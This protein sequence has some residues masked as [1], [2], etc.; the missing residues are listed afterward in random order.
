MKYDKPFLTYDQQI[1]HLKTQYKLNILNNKFALEALSSVSYYD[2]ING[3]K[4][5]MMDNGVFK[6][7]VSIE[8]L[9]LFYL[10]DKNFQNVI[11][12]H[13]LFVENFFKTKLAYVLAEDFG[14]DIKDYLA[15]KNLNYSY[16][17][18][19]FLHKVKEEIK[20][21]Y[22]KFDKYGNKFYTQQP[23]KHYILNHNHIPPWILLKNISFSNAISLYKLLKPIQKQKV[24]EN[25]LQTTNIDVNEKIQFLTAALDFIRNYR[26]QIAHNLKFVTYK[27]E[28]CKLPYHITNKII[29]DKNLSKNNEKYND[30][31]SCILATFILLN[32]SLLQSK[33]VYEIFSV[34]NT[35]PLDTPQF[36]QI[37]LL[38]SSDYLNITGLTAN[39]PLK[40]KAFSEYLQRH[41]DLK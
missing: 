34:I 31:Y 36:K 29:N 8:Y 22:T 10:L 6:H 33:Y 27:N 18:K 14:V 23:I 40:L 20:N 32:N 11:F 17:N 4:E 24:T 25:I 16:H 7:F 15:N 13:S 3:Y 35:P 2:L 21:G 28:R 30:I 19:I 5:C 9:Y 1:Q 41:N 26:N 37:Q 39:F 12:K 38:I